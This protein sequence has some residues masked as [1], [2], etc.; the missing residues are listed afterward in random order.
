MFYYCC[1]QMLLTQFIWVCRVFDLEDAEASMEPLDSGLSQGV[2]YLSWSFMMILF[3]FD[4]VL[5]IIW[6]VADMI[7]MMVD[8]A[9]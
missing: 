8:D 7:D 6:Y 5:L 9:G 1:I 4:D 3:H 2:G